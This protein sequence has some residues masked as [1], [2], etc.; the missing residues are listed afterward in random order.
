MFQFSGLSLPVLCVQTGVLGHDPKQVHL[1]GNPWVNEYVP[2]TM[3]YR[4]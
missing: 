2:L 4:S 1:F 3:A